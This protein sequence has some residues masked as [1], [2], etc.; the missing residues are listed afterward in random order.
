MLRAVKPRVPRGTRKPRIPSSVE[1]QT[2]AMSAIDPLVIHILE[3]D[4]FQSEPPLPLRVAWV[5]MLDGSLPWSGSVSPKQPIAWPAAIRGSHS[6]FWSSEPYFQIGN[7][8]RDPWTDTRLRRPE[9]AA[10]ISRHVTP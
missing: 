6:F 8:A 3:P 2:T 5:F 1:A 10:S 7:M 4:S 9:S